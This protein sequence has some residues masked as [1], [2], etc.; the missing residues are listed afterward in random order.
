MIRFLD[1][2]VNRLD[3]VI[4]A[5]S[6]SVS[7]VGEFDPETLERSKEIFD[8]L[9]DDP[10]DWNKNGVAVYH[11]KVDL[12]SGTF[13]TLI[14]IKGDGISTRLGTIRFVWV[15][16]SPENTH[17]DLGT[18]LEFTESMRSAQFARQMAEAKDYE[19]LMI[20]YREAVA[21]QVH[22]PS[23]ESTEL[24]P[25]GRF[26]GG[27]IKDLKRRLP[28]YL[29]DFKAGFNA[30]SLAAVFFLFFAC[31]APA[32]AFGGLLSVLTNGEIGAVEM[33]IATAFCGIVYALFSGQ[34]L[35]ILGSTGPVII[36]MGL[37]YPITTKFGIPYLPTLSW[38]GLWTMVILLLL[39]AFDACC[40]IRF[41]TRFTDETF[42][43]LI[44]II[45]IVE[46]VKDLV[47]VFTDQDAKYDTALL[48]LILALGTY[49]IAKSL[50]QFRKSPYLQTRIREFLSDFGPAIAILSMTGVSLLAHPVD[51]ETLN[52]P[53]TV[54]PSQPRS[55][56]VNPFDVEQ[57][58]VWFASIIPAFFVSIL[59][60]LDQNISARL[61]NN[62]DYNL[63]KGGGYHLDLVVVALLVGICSLFGLPWM[64]AATVR[65][66]NHVR[67]LANTES[68]DEG[69]E[70][71][72]G[73][74][75]N[76]FS[77]LLVHLLIGVSLLFL[78]TLR[79][80]PMSVLFGL[81]L[82]MGV[83]SMQGNQFFDR[84][85]LWLMDRER[86][87]TTSY[88]RAIPEKTI[89]LFTAIQMACLAVLWVVKASAI[90]I[91]FPVFIA[92]LVPVRMAM[93]RFFDDEH[94]ALLDAEE[95]PEEETDRV[96]D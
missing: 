94:L 54:E 91:L 19:Q 14:R 67:A 48:S 20:E 61:V 78:G 39:A 82:F 65:S 60:Y 81:F 89:H 29:D 80:I 12:D 62:P 45:F 73:V 58:W 32:I 25:T 35:T 36:F 9:A 4:K 63:Q 31:V 40:W 49:G 8:Q 68:N 90:G 55:W 95:L 7:V 41:F 53:L 26:F 23:G 13:S 42:A 70:V 69:E 11:R 33:L 24:H 50:S 88:I 18:A 1:L 84:L 3:K 46:A 17:P 2:N 34:P 52:V 71:I 10:P 22:F 30:K 77:G 43:A 38:V 79:T 28:F 51:I 74:V 76:R 47:S 56:F 37:L 15:L 92:L 83:A 21:A 86:Y 64:V 44:S 75:E 59:L 57:K 16:L 85:K 27:V 6:E 96:I 5:V 93:D 66:L 72:T 87:P